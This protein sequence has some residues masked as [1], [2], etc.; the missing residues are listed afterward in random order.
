MLELGLQGAA[1]F[2]VGLELCH[3]E[4]RG[5]C[6][7]LNSVHVDNM[8]RNVEIFIV[9]LLV[10]DDEEEVE[11]RHDWRADIN[12]VAQGP[13]AIISTSERISCGQDR[14]T[15]IERG[16]DASFCD[17]DGLLLHSFV[18]SYLILD[19]HLVELIDTT[20]ASIRE[21]KSTTFKD[22]LA[23]LRVLSDVNCET[24]G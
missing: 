21:N 10:D 14:G 7:I 1:H 19:I 20:Y 2:D 15:S 3:C 12:V 8:A 5:Q 13:R 9:L 23:S 18:D 11:T 4:V 16:V 6:S 17:R 24:D 22:K